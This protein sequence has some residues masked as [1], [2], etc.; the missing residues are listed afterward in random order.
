[1]AMIA[2][3]LFALLVLL[4]ATVALLSETSLLERDSSSP[5]FSIGAHVIYRQ[6]KASTRPSADARDIRPA[7]RGDFYYYSIINHLRIIEVLSDGRVIAVARDN[8]RLCFWPNE[9]NLRRARLD[10][11][12][13]YRLRFPRL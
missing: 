8:K 10:E 2:L 9:P 6:N 4:L 5:A 11:R 13:I 3:T 1:M 12:L 7:E